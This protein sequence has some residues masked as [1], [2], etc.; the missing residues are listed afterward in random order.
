MLPQLLALAL[1]AAG[2][3]AQALRRELDAVAGR[4]EQL[5]AR[6]LAGESVQGELNALL[7]RSQELAE[8]LEHA[9]PHASPAAPQAEEEREVEQA[10]QLRDRASTLRDQADRLAHRV[11]LLEGRIAAVL[12]SATAPRPAGRAREPGASYAALTSGNS[13]A[14]PAPTTPA[15]A[16]LVEQ[17]AQL[18]AQVEQLER[19][20]AALDAQAEELEKE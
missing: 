7:V 4:I 13:S 6:R 8:E 11:A 19:E 18:V 17:R 10:A 3:D 20:A 1:L 16:T 9:S 5:K 15:L 14:V 12:R 2:P